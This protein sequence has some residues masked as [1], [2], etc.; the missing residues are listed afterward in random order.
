MASPN[1]SSEQLGVLLGG[2]DRHLISG[3]TAEFL[4]SSWSKEKYV[5]EILKPLLDKG[6]VMGVEEKCQAEETLKIRL[7]KPE[8]R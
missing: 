5:G 1:V 3:G 8:E 6:Y 2:I 7:S 4:V